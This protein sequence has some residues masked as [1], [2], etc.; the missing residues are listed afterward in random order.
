MQKSNGSELTGS[1]SRRW[2]KLPND[3]RY[4]VSDDGLVARLLAP[5]F[6]RGRVGAHIRYSVG[7]RDR[8]A[9]R[10]VLE[11]FVGPC[12]EGMQ[13]RHLDGVGTNNDV[14]NLRWGT[15]SENR[16]DDWG[17]GRV[18]R[19]AVAPGRR[20]TQPRRRC[21]CGHVY[22]NHTPACRL[23]DCSRAWP[24]KMDTSRHQRGEACH[25]A[26]LTVYQV[27]G[28]RRRLAAGVGVR[29]LAREFSVAHATISR[30][31]LR[32]GWATA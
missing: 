13:C 2:R 14:A 4:L 17:P 29:A 21:R 15:A 22:R 31:K 3:G 12:P 26:K 1:R 32:R 11:T 7:G 6:K 25:S 9:H 30:I 24:A 5:R 16:R 20:V 10:L 19:R 8:Y 27:R 23:C 28:I 18:R